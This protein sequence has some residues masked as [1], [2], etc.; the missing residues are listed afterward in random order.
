MNKRTFN[1][2]KLWNKPTLTIVTRQSVAT[3]S[4]KIKIQKFNN[5]Q[6]KIQK[7]F[8]ADQTKKEN[9]S[10]SFMFGLIGGLLIYFLEL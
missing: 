2:K 5:N 9:N 8:E 6:D 10:T 4:N 1:T 3:N 7:I